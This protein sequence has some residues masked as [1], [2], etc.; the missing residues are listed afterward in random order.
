MIVNHSVPRGDGIARLPGAPCTRVTWPWNTWPGPRF[1]AVPSR[2]AKYLSIDVSQ[3]KAPPALSTFLPATILTGLIPYYG[4]GVKDHPLMAIGQV[5]FV[6]EPVA[7]GSPKM[8]CPLRRLWK[9]SPSSMARLRPFWMSIPLMAEGTPLIHEIDFADGSF[10]GFDDFPGA[11]GNICQAVNFEWGDVDAALAS[12][13]H[14]VEGEF[15]FPMVYAYAMEPYVAIA[16]YDASGQLMVYSSAQHPFMV[17]HDLANVFGL[18]LNSVRVIVP[19]YWWRLWKQVLYQD[20]AA[21]RGLFLENG[22]PVKL[23]L[24]VEEAFLT[25]RGDD[26]RVRIR[27][28]VDAQGRLVARQATIHLNTGAYAENSPMVCRK[29]QQSHRRAL[30]HSQCED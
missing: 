13:A 15:Y 6:G 24:S 11:A 30:S 19:L 23:Q 16:N 14:V 1:F 18:P 9:K 17:R 4:H 12:A 5:R 25:T 29:G 28:A 3:A 8:S 27:T 20:R 21:G 26:A 22:P 2:A 10:R 7:A